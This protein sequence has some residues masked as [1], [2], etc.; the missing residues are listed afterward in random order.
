METMVI[1]WK[2]YDLELADVNTYECEGDHYALVAVY[3]PE[4]PVLERMWSATVQVGEV[5]GEAFARDAHLALSNAL[6]NL[7]DKL[8]EARKIVQ[9]IAERPNT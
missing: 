1:V 8:T 6:L 2:G 3:D 7:Y 4:E 5:M 9:Q